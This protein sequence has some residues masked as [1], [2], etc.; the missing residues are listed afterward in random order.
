MLVLTRVSYEQKWYG[1][2]VSVYKDCHKET[3][4]CKWHL[5]VVQDENEIHFYPDLSV[6]FNAHKYSIEQV[7]T[8]LLYRCKTCNC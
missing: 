8:F 2:Y 5:V 3:D 7:C 6:G 1:L 4:V